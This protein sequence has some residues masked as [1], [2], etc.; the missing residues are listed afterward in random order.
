[1]SNIKK[2]S[3]LLATFLVIVAIIIIIN[4]PKKSLASSDLDY[5]AIENTLRLYLKFKAEARYTLDDGRMPEVLANDPRGSP[6]DESDAKLVRFITNNPDLSADDIGLLDVEQA[7]WAY[8]RLIKQKYDDA[9]ARGLLVPP[10]PEVIDPFDVSYGPLEMRSTPDPIIVGQSELEALPEIMDLEKA[11]GRGATL[12]R[13][14]PD[15][16]MPEQFVI[17]SIT[18]DNDLAHVIGDYS[19]AEVDLTF[20]KL[21]GQWYLVGSKIIQWHGG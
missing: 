10:T 12:P 16:I 2:L 15:V 20:V 19:Y 1:M 5:V 14:Q 9:S 11:S 3:F 7:L 21:S 13:P 8:R 17:Q 18:V 6:A 4:R